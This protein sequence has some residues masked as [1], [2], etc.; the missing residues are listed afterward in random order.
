MKMILLGAPGVGKGTQAGFI[1]E[2]L[3]IPQ[4]S[5][6]D[7][8]REAVQACT[9]LG[10][11]V[12]GVMN[13]GTL[14]ADDPLLVVGAGGAA[15]GSEEEPQ[16][17]ATTRVVAA[18][19]VISN[20]IRNILCLAIFYPPH[21]LLFADSPTEQKVYIGL[22]NDRKTITLMVSMIAIWLR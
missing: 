12:K 2:K 21:F 22:N 10:K 3:G 5:T 16:A 13:S 14:V 6:G 15:V 8:L 18:I 7:I 17:T 4:I 19:A 1:C 11:K 20:G 9:P